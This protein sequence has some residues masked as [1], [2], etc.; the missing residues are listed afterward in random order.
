VDLSHGWGIK[1]LRAVRGQG[2]CRSHVPSTRWSHRWRRHRA[3]SP[4]VRS[5]R[6][7]R[8]LCL[9]LRPSLESDIQGAGRFVDAGHRRQRTWAKAHGPHGPC[10]FCSRREE[11]L[12]ARAVGSGSPLMIHACSD[13]VLRSRRQSGQAVSLPV[14]S[15]LPLTA[16]QHALQPPMRC[17]F[18]V[19]GATEVSPIRA[20]VPLM[21]APCMRGGEEGGGL[22][23]CRKRGGGQ[24]EA[25][26]ETVAVGLGRS[27]SWRTR[28]SPAV[29]RLGVGV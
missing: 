21:C 20:G 18:R 15:P 5:W 25:V 24:V 23:E 7:P 9:P 14:A 6:P 1:L 2:G 11:R 26:P 12:F 4:A 19:C 29:E 22:G 16:H 13:V 17:Q 27:L 10:S 28:G 8:H 3:P